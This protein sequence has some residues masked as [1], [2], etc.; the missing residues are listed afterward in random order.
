MISANNSEEGIMH[1][2]L[3][4]RWCAVAALVVLVCSHL[5]GA[6]VRPVIRSCSGTMTLTLDQGI[7]RITIDKPS[8]MISP[9]GGCSLEGPPLRL[10]DNPVFDFW[11]RVNGTHTA[12][13]DVAYG[14][15][16]IGYPGYIAYQ[17][18]AI[19]IVGSQ[20][21][22]PEVGNLGAI[23]DG[24]WRHIIYDVGYAIE[25]QS[26]SQPGSVDEVYF[27]IF[28]RQGSLDIFAG[29]PGQPYP[30][31]IE[32]RDMEWRARV[33]NE[34]YS[35]DL[36]FSISTAALGATQDGVTRCLAGGYV[37]SRQLLSGVKIVGEFAAGPAFTE[38]LGDVQGR[39]DFDFNIWAPP[40]THLLHAKVVD[41]TG[42]V[43]AETDLK[44]HPALAYLRNATINIIPN[45]HNDI[46]WLDTPE[47][48]ANWRRDKVIGPAIPLLEKYPDY[49]YGLETNLF[50]MEYLRRV[51]TRAE[52]VRKFL[53]EGRLTFGAM[54]NQP[55]QSLWRDESLVRELYY[56]RKWLKEN[57]GPGVDT[58]TAW[59][60]DVPSVAMQMPQVLAKSGVKYLMLGRFL[61]GLYDWYSP[62]GSKIVVGS[63]GIYGRLSAY[64]T[65]YHPTDV[66]LQLPSLLR[67]WDTYYAQHKIPPQFPITDMT[68]YLPPT[69]ELITL[70]HQWKREVGSVQMELKFATGEEFMQSVAN[71]SRTTFPQ[72][73]GEWPNVWAYIHGPTH[74]ETVSAGREASWDLVAAEKFWTLRTLISGGSERY[75]RETFDQAWMAQI[76]PDHG[77]GGLNGD[78][79][80]ATYEAKEKEALLLGRTLLNSS[81]DWIANHAAPLNPQDIKLVILNPLS[82]NRSG[83]AWVEIP[84]PPGQDAVIKDKEGKSLSA[85]R[86][87]QVPGGT[88]RYVV[89]TRDIS[90]NGYSTFAVQFKPRTPDAV[91]SAAFKSKTFENAYYRLEFAPG[92]LKSIFDKQLGREMLNPEQFLAGEVYML[93]SVGNGAHEQGDIQH[94]SWASI[95]RASQYS[96]SWR[97]MESGPVRTGWRLDAPFRDA[98]VRLDLYAYQESKRL[99]FDIQILHWSGEKNKEFRMALPV[100]MPYAQ[101][102]YEV[103]FGALEV[104][105]DEIEGKPFEGWYNRP[106]RE[107]HPREVQDWISA[108][109]GKL[110]VMLTSSVAVADYLDADQKQER[111]T[112]LQ[113]IL[114]AARKS[115]HGL[116]NWYLQKGDHSFH[117]A[118][119]SFAGDWR[120]HY[121]FGNEV[122]SPF[123][124]AAVP[125]EAVTPSIPPFFSL[126]QTSE[127]NYVVSE[128][129]IADDQR[130]IIVRGYEMTGRDSQVVLKLPLQV[131]RANTANLI[132]EDNPDSIAM[133]GGQ[134]QFKAKGR[135]IDTFR[136]MGKWAIES[137]KSD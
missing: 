79:T 99:D 120:S 61:P 52:E 128:I 31:R 46:A 95:E 129:K 94:A 137:A 65:P 26:G 27:S 78:I 98:T 54:F 135:A 37:V 81:V 9:D 70:A 115:C 72:V 14:S 58:V 25:A 11:I 113:P 17:D 33:P 23:N 104:G 136:I 131:E 87:L 107:I 66:A 111:A 24:S 51:P 106:A 67:D 62:D 8:A 101:V 20:T 74:H 59:G 93:D 75:P 10:R 91:N 68:D 32:L 110:G 41:A 80:D 77:F 132:E 114:L 82:W 40:E 108:S 109:D 130:G 3:W 1:G 4:K 21:G 6:P 57:L 5:D 112:L 53:A 92:G 90:A 35:N 86:V 22:I 36:A 47:A 12:A 48:T 60:T 15:S 117:F 126:C 44:L 34:H 102:T 13:F 85:Q 103:P 100:N 29:A 88:T 71:D 39:R 16:G 121:R 43:L 19:N 127:P 119:T 124:S 69:Q 42:K 76:Y 123:P 49:R 134:L 133:P 18:H 63:L 56:G 116:G 125:P 96:P 38:P 64:L 118:F 7:S 73:H 2:S 89:E 30:T 97:E 55:Y 50:L 122:N 83:P 105:K 45:S 84:T 28:D